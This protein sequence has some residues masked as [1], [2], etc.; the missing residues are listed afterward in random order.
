MKKHLVSI[1]ILAASAL[2]L[3]LPACTL[4]C[5]TGSGTKVSEDRKVDDFTSLKVSGNFKVVLVQDSSLNLHITTDDNLMKYIKTSVEGGKLIVSN[6]NVCPT[7]D[8]QLTIGVRNLNGIRISGAVE[9]ASQ[10]KINT[11]DMEM[12][13]SGATKVTL[14]IN[15]ARLT[16]KGSGS[17]EINLKGQAS[18]H[19]VDL[20]GSGNVNALDFIV[21]DYNISTSGSSDCSINV[22]RELNVHSSGS[23]SI[24]YRGTPTQINNSKSGSSSIEKVN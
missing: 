6:E 20:S 19:D 14:D 15:A 7:G 22:L 2:L 17:T 23:S 21:G 5:V 24:K 18:T 12:Q 10:G 1:Y 9:M 3:L 11:G 13:L 16:T 4:T 8:Q